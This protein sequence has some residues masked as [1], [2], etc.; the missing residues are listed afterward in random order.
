MG[1]KLKDKYGRVI[2]EEKE[3]VVEVV[4]TGQ[5]AIIDNKPHKRVSSKKHTGYAAEEDLAQMTEETVE[6]PASFAGLEAE[7]V[8]T[9]LR[10]QLFEIT[11]VVEND[12]YVEVTA[13]H[14]FYRQRMNSTVWEP[15][16][17]TKYSGA[18]ACRNVLSN[19]MF[20][21]G[22]NVASDC[23][24]TIIGSELDYARMNIV[25]AFLNP[26]SGIC[27]K[28]DLSLIRDND[29]FYCLKNVGYDRGFV[30][31]SRKN[32][33]GVERTESIEN[34]VTRVAPVGRDEDGNFVWMTYQG[35]SFV[36]SPHIGDYATPR[37]EILYTGLQIGEDGVT[38]E[39]IQEKLYQ[40]AQKRF[41]DDK[42]DIPEVSMTV[43]FISLGDT[44][45][46]AQ[47]RDLD[48]VY[49][50]DILHINEEDRGYSYSAQV[51]GVQHNILTG[52][53]E[54]VTIGTP[55]KWDGVRKVATWRIPE[56]S[57][58]IIRQ[59]TIREGVFH[60]GAIKGDDIKS[61][62]IGGNHFSA[63]G[64]SAIK[65]LALEQLIVENTSEDGLLHTRFAVV[66]GM[67]SSEVEQ[68]TADG[69]LI[70]SE[71]QQTADQIYSAVSANNSSIYSFVQQT[72]SNI[73]T[74]LVN[75]ESGLYHYIN[76]TAEGT[77]ER[78]VSKS[79][80]TWIQDK[81]P[82][83]EAGGS[84]E[85]RVGDIWVESTHQGTW[86]G[87]EGFDWEHD[88]D[89]DWT[90]IQ[91]AKI[92]GW[93]NGKWELISDQQQVV[94][95]SDVV[96][97]A[98]YF[99]SR[100]I[101][102]I[103]NDE[104]LLDVY[105]SKLEQ[106]ATE[107]KSDVSNSTSTIYSFIHQTSTNVLTRVAETPRSV[108]SKTA[109]T[110]INNRGL[111][112]GDVWVESEDQGTWEKALEYSW[113][114]DSEIDWNK[115]RSNKYHIYRNGQWDEILDGTLLLDDADIEVEHNVAKLYARQLE[116]TNGEL[117]RY[118]A[119]LSVGAKEIK[120]QVNEYY[121][122]LGSSITQ[123]AREI[124]S[125][126]FS[127]NSK[128]YSYISQTSS[129]IQAR[130]SNEVDGLNSTITQTASQIKL[131]VS[132]ANSTIYST[133]TQTKNQIRSEVVNA[134]SRVMASI[135]VQ[136]NRI[137]LVVEGTGT[138]AKIKAA[139]VVTA[140]NAQTGTSS[141]LLS[142]DKIKLDGNVTLSGAMSIQDGSLSI[143]RA[144]MIGS[145]TNNLVTINNGTINATLL[146]VRSSGGIKF[147]GSQSG[148]YYDL[149]TERLK[150]MIRSVSVSGNVLTLTPWYGDP[151]NF[152]KATSLS[153][154]WGSGSNKYTV[155]A[156]QAAAGGG[157]VDVGSI[158]V[159]PVAN[160]VSSQ[161]GAYTDVYV[162]TA[163]SG[164]S[165]YDNHGSA[166]RLTM[167]FET[168]RYVRLRNPSNQVL[169]QVFIANQAVTQTYAW[170]DNTYTVTAKR[171]GTAVAS[172][173]VTPIVRPVVSQGQAYT[174]IYVATGS[175]SSSDPYVNHGAAKRLTM[176]F[177]GSNVNLKDSSNTVYAQLGMAFAWDNGGKSY[178]DTSS[179]SAWTPTSRSITVGGI[180][181]WIGIQ[182]YSWSS[183]KK[184][185]RILK[186]SWSGTAM[187]GF[188]ITPP[189]VSLTGEWTDNAYTVSATH[190]GIS[191]GSNTVYAV[192]HPISSQGSAYMDVCVA[193]GGSST[194]YEDHGSKT[195]LYLVTSSGSRTVAIRSQ[196]STSSGT[197]Y[198]QA[199]VND[200]N[201]SAGNIKK[202]V[203]I[204]GVTGTYE[205]S[206]GTI[207]KSDIDIPNSGNAWYP[208]SYSPMPSA[209]ATL[210]NLGQ[211]IPANNV[212]YVY[213]QVNVKGVT[214]VYRISVDTR[215]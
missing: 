215:G 72:A 63:G 197:V 33:L 153:G 135:N 138:N 99:V 78:L 82:R 53:L 156:K 87:A 182:E 194:G 158:S 119:E 101:A 175:G 6:I 84:H 80:Q 142:A 2:A 35:S 133:I 95:Y 139:Q 23:T 67:I 70:R 183:G 49:L 74:Q 202:N 17:T 200:G 11:D 163:K 77:E 180:S 127:D 155:T 112:E 55:E 213:F 130:V 45:E 214:K 47:Y 169:A 152:S 210:N 1:L 150:G 27:A 81:D 79:N 4:S 117:Q 211:K 188:D 93:Q 114:D 105:M 193:T 62:S 187:A 89:Y 173:S 73:L 148:E 56:I 201:L 192:V 59:N 161:G 51:V 195:R 166:T 143:S 108:V 118:Y 146:Q 25:E 88:E 65:S 39:N 159:Y 113:S 172:V 98:E 198:A 190:A 162:A 60:P 92:W 43:R 50:Y 71:I 196:N 22:F 64:K 207:A 52:R 125:D 36:D 14:I 132:N 76:Q 208:S 174:D 107:I 110:S 75:S 9:R 199:T 29:V 203:T 42:I 191:A 28:Y 102:G 121:N 106:T 46:Y 128:L 147:V 126:V 116:Y 186:D 3:E 171:D 123:T 115:L 178:G 61:E 141:V 111:R 8:P 176:A 149:T 20:D 21:L 109:P 32:L 19:A 41:T 5:T 10:D 184:A 37:L 54:S 91:G 90:Q 164:G 13:L 94:S 7:M 205:G 124:R 206:G 177:S 122:K 170:N 83:T 58:T 145:D 144:V 100:K 68:R 69:S 151:I 137:G 16:E 86:D 212:G 136:A 34:V 168:D 48:K 134:E 18:A 140:I 66:E 31:Q 85:A 120:A 40:A 157:T 96:N 24:D 185:V 97:T 189:T 44:E 104:G 26:E 209:D 204:F 30:I 167:A 103:V 160:I 12:G 131:E 165:G 57:G 181:Q 129:Q 179:G 154:E 15:N 38:A